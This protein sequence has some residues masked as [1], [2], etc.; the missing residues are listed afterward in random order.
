MI[1]ILL[2]CSPKK[3]TKDRESRIQAR[4]HAGNAPIGRRCAE[5]KRSQ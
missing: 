1:V 5:W 2:T 4:R 3:C